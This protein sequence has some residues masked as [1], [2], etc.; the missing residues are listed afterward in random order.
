MI[1]GCFPETK[2]DKEGGKV[3]KEEFWQMMMDYST[4]CPN[5]DSF[6]SV[7]SKVWKVD[8]NP[9]SSVDNIRVMHLLGLMRQRL[10]TLANS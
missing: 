5:D 3:T 9:A 7:V 4:Q 6:S 1:L 10:I 2:A 8:E